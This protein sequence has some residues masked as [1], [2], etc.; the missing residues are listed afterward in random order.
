LSISEIAS[1]APPTMANAKKP[2]P[3][4]MSPNAID[5]SGQ[6]NA[7]SVEGIGECRRLPTSKWELL[8][9]EKI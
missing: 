6:K 5:L 2:G 4:Q 8:S 9:A 3:R 7:G 1:P